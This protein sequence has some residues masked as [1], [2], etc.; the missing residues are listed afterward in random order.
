MI[1][2]ALYRA[3]QLIFNVV[4]LIGLIF[5]FPIAVTKSII[6]T[7]RLLHN[8]NEPTLV[9]SWW[10]D[11]LTQRILSLVGIEFYCPP[12]YTDFSAILEWRDRKMPR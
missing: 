6:L 4:W 7:L 11:T 10:H 12:F 5:L 3:L 1:C 9:S 8:R 2:C